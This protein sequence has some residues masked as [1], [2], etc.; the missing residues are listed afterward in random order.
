[1]DGHSVEIRQAP[2]KGLGVVATRDVQH[3]TRVMADQP[4]IGLPSERYIEDDLQKVLSKLSVGQRSQ[5]IASVLS[6]V[7]V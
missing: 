2:K 1:M 5:L 6:D 4:L 3:G 7:M